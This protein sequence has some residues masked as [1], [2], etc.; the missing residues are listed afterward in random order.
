MTLFISSGESEVLIR[1][2]FSCYLS[3]S[4]KEGLIISDPVTITQKCSL[5]ASCTVPIFSYY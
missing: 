3:H 2:Q 4:E 1:V 5:T